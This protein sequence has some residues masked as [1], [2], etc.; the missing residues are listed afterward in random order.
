MYNDLHWRLLPGLLRTYRISRKMNVGYGVGGG[1]EGHRG[2]ECHGGHRWPKSYIESC[3]SLRGKVWQIDS[4][5]LHALKGL[6][7]DM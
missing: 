2:P 6:L 7:Q 1:A 4:I 5:G 3:T